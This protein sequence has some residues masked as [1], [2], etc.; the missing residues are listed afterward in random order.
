MHIFEICAKFRQPWEKIKI[1]RMLIKNK[2]TKDQKH[3][4]V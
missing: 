4:V 2:Q 3:I 1:K